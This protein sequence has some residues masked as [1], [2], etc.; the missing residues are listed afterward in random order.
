MQNGYVVMGFVSVLDEYTTFNNV[1]N[2]GIY[3]YNSST[4]ISKA[5][6]TEDGFLEVLCYGTAILQR[7]TGVSGTVVRRVYGTSWSEWA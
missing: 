5:P 1:K 6:T 4:A 3:W 7:F 2:S